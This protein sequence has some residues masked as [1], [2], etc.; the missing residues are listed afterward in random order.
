[1]L[2]ARF[3]HLE[4]LCRRQVYKIECRV[5]HYTPPPHCINTEQQFNRQHVYEIECRIFSLV[6]LDPLHQVRLPSYL[7]LSRHQSRYCKFLCH[8]KSSGVSYALYKY[9]KE[10]YLAI[11]IS[12]GFQIFNPVLVLFWEDEAVYWLDS[13]HYPRLLQSLGCLIKS[14]VFLL[15]QFIPNSWITSI[16]IKKFFFKFFY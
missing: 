6:E 13:R 2:S 8:E 9:S 10:A 1:M 14:S 12:M 4:T 16:L 11:W 7:S 5:A 15:D 3:F